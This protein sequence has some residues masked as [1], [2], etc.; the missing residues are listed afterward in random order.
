MR[1][2]NRRFSLWLTDAEFAHLTEQAKAA[3][4]KKEPVYP[5][6]PKRR[7]HTGKAAGYILSAFAGDKRHR[8]EYQSD[9][10]YCKCRAQNFKRQD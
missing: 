3:G 2:R 1:Y 5:Q 6:A 9:R 4:L 10:A 8:R 7:K